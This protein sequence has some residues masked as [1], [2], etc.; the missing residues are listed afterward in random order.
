VLAARLPCSWALLL[1]LLMMMKMMLLARQMLLV[2]LA[3]LVVVLLLLALLLQ[4]ARQ[5]W[6]PTWQP[7]CQPS[8]QSLWCSPRKLPPA[9][10]HPQPSLASSHP[11]LLQLPSWAQ[12]HRPHSW[13]PCSIPSEASASVQHSPRW[14]V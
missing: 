10:L 11:E 4:P 14:V 8:P 3:L 9:W 2:L 6:L 7:P 12:Q 5:S 13:Q 1:L